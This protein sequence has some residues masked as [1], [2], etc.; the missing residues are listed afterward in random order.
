MKMLGISFVSATALLVGCAHLDEKQAT[1][2]TVAR[3][4]CKDGKV[5]PPHSKCGLNKGVDRNATAAVER[6]S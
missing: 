1:P 3:T 5:M 6:R 4:V 2:A